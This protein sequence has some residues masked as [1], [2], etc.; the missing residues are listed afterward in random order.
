MKSIKL[1]LAIAVCTNLLYAQKQ[2]FPFP[3]SAISDSVVLEKTLTDIASKIIPTYKNS[4]KVDSLDKLSKL[5]ILADNYSKA[6]STINQYREAYAGT[7]NAVV[8]LMAYDVY[9]AA[10]NLEK[11]QKI[12]FPHALELVFNKKFKDLPLK[13]SF[14]IADSF[15]EDIQTHKDKFNKLLSQ[16]KEADSISYDSAVSLG[17]AYI[18]YKTFMNVKSESLKLLSAREN[19]IYDIESFDLKTS[20]G[21][22]I[23][24]T[25]TR[26]KGITSPLPVIYTNNIYAGTY[27]LALGKRAAEYGYVGVVANARGKRTSIDN[28]EPFEHEADDSYDIIDWISKQKWSDGKVGMIGGSYLGFGQWAAT[29]KLHPA[30]KTIVPQVAVG[31]G[32]DYPMNNNV[33]MSY[34]LQWARY[35]TNNKFTDEAEFK[36]YE[37][38]IALYKAW[39]KSGES[40]RKLDSIS[41][42]P[43]EIF[44]RW[45]NHPSYDEYWK[46]MI[47][48][49]QEFAKIKIPVL[50]TTGFYDADQLG[51]L[52]YFREHYKHNE[53]PY[54]YLVIGP[55]DHAGGQSFA[56]N[57]LYNGYN[58]DHAAKINISDLAYSWFDYILKNK[59]KPE[60]LKDKVN[61]QIM[62]TNEWYH[63]SNLEKSHNAVLKFYL[64]KDSKSNLVLEKEKSTNTDFTTQTIDFKKRDEKSI[65]FKSK[66]DS[67]NIDNQLAFQTSVL[68]KDIIINGAFTAQLK[69]S[70]NKKD[71]DVKI[72][73]IQLKPDGKFFYLSDYLGRASYAKNREKRQ[74]LIPG[75]IETIPAS[76]SMFVGKK[77]LKGSRLIVLLGINK[78]PYYQI[79][80]G[81]GKD[82]SD[83]TIA[84]AKIPL[85]VKWYNDSYIEIPVLE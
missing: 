36:N 19:E 48:Y 75:K 84:D 58:V 57:T 12:I 60:F 82:V 17:I 65:Y 43:N 61:I 78:S 66:K 41:G 13:Y 38:W 47:P 30:L 55:Y 79:N 56:A 71:V 44:Q 10:K 46:K 1:I 63:S 53:N 54:H 52:Y 76:N 2:K 27:D 69:A 29:K 3:K 40:F 83:E 62:D 35:V 37:K 72:D 21:G 31:I 7:N 15:D 64:K 5:E 24:L 28:I 70:I 11:D 67:I 42:K 18:N 22:N 45:L 81:S 59:P 74:L 77:I 85:K 80:Y 68:D 20:H 39:Y 16:Q 6:S 50:T 8:K 33:F 25:V 9:A 34:M 73:L 14:R 26:K 23:T 32:I 51:A 4:N 49:K